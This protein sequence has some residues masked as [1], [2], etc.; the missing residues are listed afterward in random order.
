MLFILTFA[1]YLFTLALL[2]CVI[3]TSGTDTQRRFHRS[4]LKE[5]RLRAAWQAE[6]LR[7]KQKLAVKHLAQD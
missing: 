1:F 4:H 2:I 5:A 7:T 3:I 6:K